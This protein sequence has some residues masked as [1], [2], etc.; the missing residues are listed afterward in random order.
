MW[1]VLFYVNNSINDIHAFSTMAKAH[2]FMMKDS[3]EVYGT[4]RDFI[5]EGQ[6]IA[7][8][9][10]LSNTYYRMVEVVTDLS[11]S[12]VPT[13]SCIIFL[14][15]ICANVADLSN[16]TD[17]W[18]IKAY[19]DS[20]KAA[21]AMRTEALNYKSC[22]GGDLRNGIDYIQLYVDNWSYQ[23]ELKFVEYHG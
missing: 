1:A 20:C 8:K 10:N 23:W 16:E 17:L 15:N 18:S 5:K 22:Y 7:G 3:Y 4:E 9:G 13:N 2:K 12:D 11:I 14:M 6:E 21:L 19:R